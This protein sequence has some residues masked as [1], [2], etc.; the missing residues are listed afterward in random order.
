MNEKL[1]KEF[2]CA[3]R[4]CLEEEDLGCLGAAFTQQPGAVGDGACAQVPP[5]GLW[6]AI[7]AL[8]MPSR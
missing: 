1:N 2:V 5:G 8:S 6:R 3:V 7:F 4:A